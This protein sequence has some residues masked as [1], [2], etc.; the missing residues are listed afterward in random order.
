MDPDG[1]EW[2][3]YPGYG[4]IWLIR[5]LTTWEKG[6]DSI[7]VNDVASQAHIDIYTALWIY[8]RLLH[9]YWETSMSASNPSSG[10]GGGGGQVTV[11]PNKA[12]AKNTRPAVNRQ[13]NCTPNSNNGVLESLYRTATAAV[14]TAGFFL[15][16]GPEAI[17]FD[18]IHPLQRG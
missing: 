18:L 2:V 17:A 1:R 11:G 3:I 12:E 16:I 8:E 14:L 4:W 5:G 7:N 13:R 10:G 6:D 15:G 9:I